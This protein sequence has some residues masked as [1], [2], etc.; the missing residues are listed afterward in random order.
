MQETNYIITG[1]SGYIGSNFLLK[2]PK[3]LTVNRNTENLFLQD[4]NRNILEDN[5]NKYI[6][7]AFVPDYKTIVM[8]NKLFRYI[9]ENSNLDTL[10]ESYDED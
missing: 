4:S 6:G 2:N 3:T 8:L 10:E 7:F 9:K 1:S 5:K